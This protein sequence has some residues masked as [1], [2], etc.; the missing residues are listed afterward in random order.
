MKV[1]NSQIIAIKKKRKERDRINR[2]LEEMKIV[3]KTSR[4]N[5]AYYTGIKKDISL[6]TK[7][8]FERQFII[9]KRNF[10]GCKYLQL[11][12][13]FTI[14]GY[15]WNHSG[16]S[17]EDFFLNAYIIKN[18]TPEIVNISF[19]EQYKNLEMFASS[20]IEICQTAFDFPLSGMDIIIDEI[21]ST[22]ITPDDAYKDNI[23]KLIN[24]I[25]SALFNYDAIK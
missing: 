9:K 10:N 20:L 4:G 2:Y 14:K 19:D 22:K 25:F 23:K 18:D 24:F 12:D 13:E 7:K 1:S 21:I 17:A 6:H 3:S 15:Y 5:V 11:K 16:P 8:N